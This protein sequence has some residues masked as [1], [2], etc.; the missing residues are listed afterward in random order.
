MAYF[1]FFFESFNM[2]LLSQGQILPTSSK[3]FFSYSPQLELGI[4]QPCHHKSVERLSSCCPV[5]S[6]WEGY[7][8]PVIY[9]LMIKIYIYGLGFLEGT[10]RKLNKTVQKLHRARGPQ[11]PTVT[12]RF[13]PFLAHLRSTEQR[14]RS[15]QTITRLQGVGPKGG[16]RLAN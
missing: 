7:F 10:T 1:F 3:C 8:F 14:K 13:S 2:G 5:K 6:N 15:L 4:L 16:D 12:P 9:M 11:G